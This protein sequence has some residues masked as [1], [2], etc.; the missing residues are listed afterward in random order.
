MGKV[1]ANVR[2]YQEVEVLVGVY[3]FRDRFA[4]RAAR[5]AS[6]RLQLAQLYRFV[7]V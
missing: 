2:F 5:F 4:Q 3:I 7:I 1:C 6:R